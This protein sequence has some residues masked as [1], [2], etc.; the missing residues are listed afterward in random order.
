MLNN[1]TQQDLNELF[2]AT[3]SSK[4]STWLSKTRLSKPL[5]Q[6]ISENQEMQSIE[7]DKDLSAFDAKLYDIRDFLYDRKFHVKKKKIYKRMKA[8]IN[9]TTANVKLMNYFQLPALKLQPF[10]SNK[11]IYFN[12]DQEKRNDDDDSY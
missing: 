7:I 2:L 3:K 10:L 6:P 5:R 1:I 11:A 4:L 12:Q 8:A 9:A